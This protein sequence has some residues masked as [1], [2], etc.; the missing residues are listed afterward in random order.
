MLT[1][2]III[3]IIYITESDIN[4]PDGTVITPVSYIGQPRIIFIGYINQLHYCFNSA[5]EGWS[6]QK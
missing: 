2:I 5:R 3:C 1:I 4:K 6:K